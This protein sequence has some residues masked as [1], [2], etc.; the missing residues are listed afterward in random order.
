MPVLIRHID[1]IARQKQRDVLYLE[2]HP[3]ERSARRQYQFQQDPVRA[4]ILLWFDEHGVAW[5]CCGPY[6]DPSLMESYRG[7]I[8][9]DVPFDETLAR[10][11]E[12][13]DF[14]EHADGTIRFEGARFMLLPLA[15]AMKNAAHDAPGFWENLDTLN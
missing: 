13:R 15:H 8:Y 3:Q 7:Q 4:H 12:L 1:E 14:L 5:Q 9:I 2:F 10:Y 6:A 11:Q